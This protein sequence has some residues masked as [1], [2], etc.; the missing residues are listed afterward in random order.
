VDAAVAIANAADATDVGGVAVAVAD[1]AV[2]AAARHCYSCRHTSKSAVKN[3]DS[4]AK[5]DNVQVKST[6]D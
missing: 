4:A 1:L 2:V 6:N 3:A 5:F